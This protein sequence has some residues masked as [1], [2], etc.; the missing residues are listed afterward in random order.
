MIGNDFKENTKVTLCRKY[1]D[2]TLEEGIG[3]IGKYITEP[4]LPSPASINEVDH[5]NSMGIQTLVK[6]KEKKLIL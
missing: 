6:I 1:E 5:L 2:G 3:R 4:T